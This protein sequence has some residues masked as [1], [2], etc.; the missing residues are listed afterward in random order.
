M[1][2]IQV[3]NSKM[4]YNFGMVLNDKL[5]YLWKFKIVM[6]LPQIFV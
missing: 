6:D 3:Y 5:Q 4:K 1:L 2:Q